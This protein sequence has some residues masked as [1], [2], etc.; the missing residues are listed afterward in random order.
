MDF[1][2]EV[3]G[4]ELERGWGLKLAQLRV[5]NALVDLVNIMSEK[6]QQ[7]PNDRDKCHKYNRLVEERVHEPAIIWPKI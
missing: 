4:C 7:R 6:W 2:W 1:Y 3:L 5:G